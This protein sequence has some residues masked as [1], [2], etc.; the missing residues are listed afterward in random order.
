MNQRT[1]VLTGLTAGV[2]AVSAMAFGFSK[3][4]SEI[5]LNGSVSANGKWDV[6]VTAASA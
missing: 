2:L 5:S 6:A 3:W 1:R 4:S